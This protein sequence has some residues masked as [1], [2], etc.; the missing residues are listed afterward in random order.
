M[1]YTLNVT[2]QIVNII[3]AIAVIAFFAYLIYDTAKFTRGLK[4]SAVKFESELKTRLG[5]VRKNVMSQI[6]KARK[7]ANERI[8]VLAK[9]NERLREENEKYKEK[10]SNLGYTDIDLDM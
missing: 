4:K 8:D 10:L 7:E 2:G 1:E 9:E 5:S 3:V 6:A